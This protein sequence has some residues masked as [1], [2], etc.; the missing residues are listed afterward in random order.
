M[1]KKT[2]VTRYCAADPCCFDSFYEHPEFVKLTIRVCQL[3]LPSDVR[4][5]VVNQREPS[6][7]STLMLE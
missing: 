4:Y 6:L 2:V 7:G 3:K 1:G 5:S